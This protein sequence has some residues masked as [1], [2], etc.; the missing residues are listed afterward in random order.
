M[1]LMAVLWAWLPPAL[2]LVARGPQGLDEFRQNV[3]FA[4]ESGAEEARDGI[5]AG[6]HERQWID[7][8]GA[9]DARVQALE[10]EHQHV[11][12]KSGPGIHHEPARARVGLGLG[13]DVAGHVAM[14]DEGAAGRGSR[15]RPP[16]PPCR[17]M[18]SPVSRA[19]SMAKRMRSA[20]SK[21][22]STRPAVF[23]VVGREAGGILAGRGGRSPPPSRRHPPR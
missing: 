10:I 13:G 14:G 11:V 9:D 23:Q 15:R 22:S 17:S 3:L 5:L 19:R 1:I 7:V 18:A 2:G 8:E 20:F 6:L 21:T 16:T 12:V 4:R